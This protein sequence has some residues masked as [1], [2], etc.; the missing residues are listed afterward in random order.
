MIAVGIAFGLLTVPVIHHYQLRAAT[1]SYI[2][3]LKAKDE[4]MELSQ[5]IPLPVPDW[6]KI[7]HHFFSRAAALLTTNYDDVF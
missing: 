3:E 6:E 4:P 7:A 5:V 2:A 1:E